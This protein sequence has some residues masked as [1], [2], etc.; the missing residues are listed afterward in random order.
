MSLPDSL[1]PDAPD[2][3]ENVKAHIPIANAQAQQNVERLAQSTAGRANLNKHLQSVFDAG[4][5]RQVRLQR[6]RYVAS[7]WSEHASSVSACQTKCSHC[8]HINVLVPKTEAK[9]MAKAIGRKMVT[10]EKTFKM[11]ADSDALSHFGEPCVFLMEGQC[12]IYAHRPLMC[13]TLVSM[14]DT[15]LLC[16]LVPGASIPVP[17]ANSQQLQAI[18]V[19]L[20]GDD[21]CADVRDWFSLPGCRMP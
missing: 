16:Q 9:I 19:A 12:S 18:F 15:D 7:L 1:S 8:C 14:A 13:R 5:N 6:L 10:P 20:V 11:T 17:Y 2:L 4:A 3:P 21:D